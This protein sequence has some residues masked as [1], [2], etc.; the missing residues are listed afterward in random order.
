MLGAI[1]LPAHA[2]VHHRRHRPKPLKTQIAELL[3][4]P[5][6]SRA[7]W[8][9]VVTEMDGK[10]IYAMNEGQLFQPASNNKMFTTATALALLGPDATTETRIVAKGVFNG[11][12]KL[13]GDVVLVGA[14]DANLS[15]RALQYVEPADRPN[16]APPAPDPLRYLA[17][18]ADQVA[19]TGLK[20]VNGDVVGDDTLFPWE[21]YPE[22]WT[23]DDAVWGYGAPVSALTINDNQIKVTVTPADTAGKPATVSLSPA[24]PYYRLDFSVMTGSPKSPSSIEM[25]RMPGSR[26]LR[27]YGSIAVDAQPDEEEVAIEDPAEYAAV[28]L[29]SLLEARGVEVTGKARAQHRLSTDTQGFLA[30]SAQSVVDLSERAPVAANPVEKVLAS[31]T[32]PPLEENLVVTNKVSQ[33]LHA[34]LFLHQLG[35]AVLGDGS[36]A[37]GVRVVRVFLTDKVGVDPD[38]F[39]FFDGSGLSGHDLVTPRAAAKLLQYAAEQPWFADWKRSLPIGG[40][41]GTL[42]ERFPKAPLKDHLFAK[43]GTLGEARALS[44]YLECASGKTVIFSIMVGN[45]TPRTHADREAMDKIVA[46][47]AETN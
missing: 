18:M 20:V 22:D 43:T 39:V 10:P 33:N 24:V 2:K 27:I 44:G 41:D 34:E 28:A 40:E 4:D 16:P 17:Q 29:K 36:T 37:A 9:I 42:A 15:G 5:A 23:I 14:G 3:D 26:E 12:A 7:H 8:G 6:V 13:A 25:E 30:E 45:H 38:D 35:V 47:I 1:C 11:P 19:A 32:S 46:A 21:P 31:H